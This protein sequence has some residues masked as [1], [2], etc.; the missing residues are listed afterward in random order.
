MK[1]FLKIL[2]AV[3][4]FLLILIIVIPIAFKKPILK[5]VQDEI[6]TTVNAKVN[7]DLRLSLLKGFPD[8]FVE[9]N[10]LSVVGVGPFENDTLVAF[11][12]FG[13]KVDLISAIKMENIDI[14]S[15]VL[16]HP[17]IYGL[18]LEDGKANWDIMKDTTTSPTD[19]TTSTTKFS[20]KVRKFQIIDGTIRYED[21][22]GHMDATLR[23]FDFLM[24]GNL[25]SD[26]TTLKIN[27]SVSALSFVM[28]HIK[29]L[30]N[31]SLK[32]KF[33]VDADMQK[34]LFTLKDN[35]LSLNDLVLGWNG[36][37]GM[38]GDSIVTN[39]TFATKKTDFRSILS[40]VPAIYMNDFKDVKTSGSMKLDG[41]IKGVYIDSI[42]PSVKVNLAVKNGMFKYPDLPAAAE[43][44]A[45]D[46]RLFFD[47]VNN[48]NSTVDVD[49]FH[50]ELASNPVDIKLKVAHPISDPAVDG[51]FVGKID[52]G[53]ITKIVPLDSTTLSGLIQSNVIFAGT[54]S[55]LDK[56][57]YEQFKADGSVVLKDLYY[58]SPD[59]PQ[60]MTI[61][62]SELLFSPKFVDLKSFDMKVGKSDFQL[63]GK[64]TD[65]IPYVFNNKTIKGNFAFTSS[66]I[67]A[68][69]FLAGETPADTVTDTTQLT[70]F[71]VPK[72]IDF[73]L[74]SSL[75]KVLYDKLE[76]SDVKGVIVLRDG[77]AVLDN[78]GMNLLQGSMVMNGEYNTQ[79]VKNPFVDFGLK[80]TDIDIKSACSS[81]SMV[82][83][84]APIA[85]SVKGKVSTDLTL[86]STLDQHMNPVMNS[87]ASKGK[88]SS[89]SVEIGNSTLFTKLADVLKNDKL[90]QMKV[91]DLNLSY[92]IANGRLYVKPFNIKM[93]KTTLDMGG[94]QGLDQTLNYAMALTLPRTDVGESVMN[95]L[96]SAAAAR[97]INIKPSET[98]KMKV[99]V[100]G[101]FSNPQIKP[102]LGG[103]GEDVTASVKEQVKEKATEVIQEKKEEVK[104]VAS[105]KAQEILKKA[106]QEAQ[107]VRDAAQKAAA[108]ERQKANDLAD[109]TIKEAKGNP[110]AEA[111]A[112][113]TAD[114]IRKEGD[115]KANDIVKEADA[116][117]NA[118]LQK[119]QE[120]A[121]KLK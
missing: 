84:Y 76:V 77:K 38:P 25:A 2:S 48:D 89:K 117:A 17:V 5:K 56:A 21:R 20:V 64:I 115:K 32:G 118:I 46:T 9:L 34:F 71:E 106:Q 42:M 18:V 80:A 83:K 62:T 47:G 3:I 90:K 39:L 96:T 103:S 44:I 114:K 68:N 59:L 22:Q 72:N 53:T 79:D 19:T 58:K 94:D 31:A 105:E 29:Y 85:E 81:F 113:K 88:L 78:L 75:K 112:K 120:E 35:E 116:K 26:F 111:V 107:D 11:K 60:G 24:K 51:S 86:K 12:S 74:T 121:D 110:L 93:G 82:A 95:S 67:D 36:T 55:M 99:K 54:M 57:Q 41:E 23:G 49:R 109:K 70:L 50:V 91:N 10:H 33:D 27:T 28:D 87:V 102:D 98:I 63:A 101:T 52:L 13:V 97:G 40:M 108:Y 104:A 73:T 8:L 92:E 7:F 61:S 100:G 15:I 43:N 119:A 30:N 65:F 45:I 16:D 37:V 4:L 69:E 14:K 6:N 1:K 66:L